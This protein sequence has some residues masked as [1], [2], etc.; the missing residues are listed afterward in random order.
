LRLLE[1]QLLPPLIR[2]AVKCTRA[3]NVVQ[4]ALERFRIESCQDCG[5][6]AWV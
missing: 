5:A 3:Q 6:Q 4:M 2:L 1:I